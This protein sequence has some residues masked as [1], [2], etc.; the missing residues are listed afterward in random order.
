MQK[1]LNFVSILFCS[2]STFLGPFMAAESFISLPGP[3]ISE[4]K[5]EG[6]GVHV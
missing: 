6:L 4:M 3:L 1:S 2:S 5:A